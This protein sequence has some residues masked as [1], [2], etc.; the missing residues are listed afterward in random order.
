MSKREKSSVARKI[1]ENRAAKIAA[2]P[3]HKCFYCQYEN[4]YY[5]MVE[6]ETFG[7]ICKSTTSCRRRQAQLK[8]DEKPSVS[9]RR[10]E[11]NTQ[12]PPKFRL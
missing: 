8:E 1:A 7:W 12:V 4:K 5:Q 2:Q 6:D 3:R 11:R 10:Y 9:D